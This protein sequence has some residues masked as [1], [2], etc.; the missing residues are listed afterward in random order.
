MKPN[1][2]TVVAVLGSTQTL[3]WAS[4]YYLPAVLGAPIAAGLG[5]STTVFFGV[6][7]VSLLLGAA[8]APYIGALIDRHGGRAVLTASSLVI[9][10]GLALLG[11]AQGIVGLTIAWLVLG[12][13]MAMGLYDP[14][15][16]TLTHLYGRDARAAITGITLIAGFASTVGWP[17]SAWF[18]HAFGWREAC[19]IWAGVNL[20]VSLPLNWLVIPPTPPLHPTQQRGGTAGEVEPPRGAMPILAFYFAATAFVTGALQAHLLRFLETAGATETAAIIAGTLVG[21]AQVGAR[22][23]EF[24][25]MRALHPVW[26]ARIA[27]ILH[28]AGALLLAAF[29]P[30]AIVPFAL[31]YGAGNGMI[32]IAKGTLPLAIFG[33]AGYGLRNGILSVPARLTLSAAPFLFG[34]LL[35]RIGLLAVLLT[36]AL[37]LAA[38][39]SLWLLRT[40]PATTATIAAND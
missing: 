5:L 20:L 3:A 30:A 32:T 36:V 38:F 2:V 19:L 26:S 39:G 40:R 22:V 21:P 34:L 13:G 23:C 33:P 8:I 28:P 24:A 6:F 11:L 1:K 4:S 7:S 17:A 29:G 37:N 15:F 9:A 10:A 35:D 16:A 31:A 14:A 18:E 12:A 27:A 25:L